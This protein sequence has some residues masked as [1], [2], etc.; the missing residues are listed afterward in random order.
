MDLRNIAIIAH[1]D[2]GKTTLV[3]ALLRA[4]GS[5]R[6]NQRVV[7]RAL[8]SNDLER[9][10]GITILSKC[11]SV[12]WADTRINIVDTPGHADF[13]GEVERILSMVDG[14][15]VL[16]DASEG[17]MPQTKFVLSKALAL[18][19]RPIVVV[20]KVDRPDQRA[21]QVQDEMFDLF[22]SLSA[23]DEQLDFPTLFASSRQGWASDAPDARR[24]DM[25]ALFEEILSHVPPPAIEPDAPFRMLVT[26][27][28]ADPFLGRVLTGRIASGMVQPNMR[29][30]ALSRDGDV[31]EEF[32]ITRVTA[33]RGLERCSSEAAY[34]GDIVAIAGS[35]IAT[36]ADTLAAAS[37]EQPL[38][39]QPIDPSTIGITISINDSPLS[40]REGTRLTSRMLRARLVREAEG[41]V[42]IQVS[43]A[44]GRDSFLVSG[45]GELQLAVLIEQMRREGYEMSI[46]RPEVLY[47]TDPVS[48]Q[49]LEPIE[50]VVIDVDE[51]WSGPVIETLGA[52]RA[53]MQDMSHVGGKQRL[54][55]LCP[56]RGL[57]GYHGE[58]LT[59]TR[60]TG[61]MNRVFHAYAPYRGPLPGR[62]NGV[63]V[64]LERGRASAYALFNLEERGRM[65]ID[66]GTE[67]Y[68][69]MIIGENSRSDDLDVNPL[70]SKQLT[71]FRAA[72]KDDAID[73]TP[74]ILMTLE[75]A[76]AWI[77]DDELVEVTPSSLRLRKRYLD[78]HERKRQAQR[79]TRA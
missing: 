55:F 65:L 71:N 69:G 13:G 72:G 22:A 54:V 14:V 56:S 9:E 45:R 74:P 16:V 62:R 15:L 31:I 76:I 36:V 51:A 1:V 38:A 78:I 50:E 5:V 35:A 29:I 30:R 61:I 33:F 64:S 24:D 3:D 17:P 11:T 6:E 32:R 46:S 48:G 66:P 42:A 67:V 79:A 52:R 12:T 75:K 44:V 63:L 43:E 37:V 21:Y 60:G 53:E 47:R 23:S 70:K 4:S 18:G 8:D 26:T 73:L 10:R 49:R 57:L 68:P 39:A 40:G 2:H 19:L 77:E 58:F 41:N 27:L 7:E 28:E 25:S 34:A 20:N 59:Q